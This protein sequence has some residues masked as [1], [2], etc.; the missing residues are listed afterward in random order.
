MI[1]RRKS[2]G[3]LSWRVS[4][5]VSHIQGWIYQLLSPIFWYLKL[6]N[7]LIFFWGC[8]LTFSCLF[9]ALLSFIWVICHFRVLVRAVSYTIHGLIPASC[10][11]GLISLWVWM[12]QLT[13]ITWILSQ[14]ET[15]INTVFTFGKTW[16]FQKITSVF[17]ENDP[18]WRKSN[19]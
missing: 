2:S 4:G 13:H 18:E 15:I 9:L 12:I 14:A 7:S 5:R 3:D 17:S 8:R 11:F 10:V 1:S 6:K 19:L 16:N